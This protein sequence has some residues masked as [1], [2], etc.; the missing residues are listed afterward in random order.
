MNKHTATARILCLLWLLCHGIFPSVAQGDTLHAVPSLTADR[1]LTVRE[2]YLPYDERH[3]VGQDSTDVHHAFVT[4]RI[5]DDYPYAEP[6]E[7]PFNVRINGAYMALYND[8]NYWGGTVDFGSFE[9]QDGADIHID[10]ICKDSLR[11]F[12]LLPLSQDYSVSRTAPNALRLTTHAANRQVTLIANGDGHTGQ[13]LHLF[14]NPITTVE[15]PTDADYYFGPGYHNLT[16]RYGG[17]LTITARQHVYVAPGAVVDGTLRI[18][19]A[20]GAR[21]SGGGMVVNTGGSLL[22]IDNSRHCTVSGITLHGHRPQGWQATVYGSEYI[23]VSHLKILCTRYASTDGLNFVSSSHCQTDSCFIRAC[24]DAIAIKG[25]G[26][27]R[28]DRSPEVTDLRFNHLQLWNDCNNAFSIGAET[29]ARRFSHISLTDTDILFSYDDPQYHTQLDERAALGLCC[30]HGTFFHDIHYDDIRVYHCERL[31][32]MGFKPSFWFGTIPGDQSTQGGIR[33]VTFRNVRSLTRSDSPIANEIL[34]NAWQQEG[35]PTKLIEDIRFDHVMAEGQPIDRVGH[36]LLKINH[37]RLV[38]A[39]CF[40][41]SATASRQ[42][43][44]S[45]VSLQPLFSDGMVLQQQSQ[46]PVW[47]TATPGATITVTPSWNR[48]ACTATADSQGHWELRLSTPEAGGP[49]EMDILSDRDT[50][51]TLHDILIGE[52]WLCSGQS[53]M[54]MPLTGWG[55]IMNYEREIAAADHPQLRLLHVDYTMSPQPENQLRTLGGGW[56]HCTSQSVAGFSA[57]AYFFGRD[58]LQSRQVPVGLIQAAWGGTPAEAWV[59]SEGLSRLPDYKEAVARIRRLPVDASERKAFYEDELTQW[60]R[61]L[62]AD[63]DAWHA[64]ILHYGQPDYDDRLWDD[65]PVPGYASGQGY[66]DFDGI[67]WYRTTI[68]IPSQWA[69]EEL[70]LDLGRIDDN[71]LTFFN[72]RPIGHTDGYAEH[73]RYHVPSEWVRPGKAVITVRVLDIGGGAGLMD[74]VRLQGRPLTSR[75]KMRRA[76]PLHTLAAQPRNPLT[77][78][79]NACMLYNAMIHPLAPY[80]IKGVLWYQGEDN[81]NRAYQ[82]RELLPC[83]IDDWRN[84]WGYGFPF[85]IAQLANYQPRKPQ[86]TASKW[87]ELREAQQLTARHTPQCA[88]ACLIDTGTADDIHPK[89]KQAAGHRL[90]LLARALTYGEDVEYSGPTYTGHE[91]EGGSV[92]LH[93]SHA[94]GLHFTAADVHSAF[95]VAGPDHRFHWA[96]ARIEGTDIVVSSPDVPLPVAV[97]YGWA[98]NPTA[99]LTNGSGLPAHPFRTDDWPGLTF[100]N[101][102][103]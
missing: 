46:V 6:V 64:G 41:P 10:I 20:D 78:A 21:I 4:H 12:E 100:G 62:Q 5:P 85:Y 17:P 18:S 13:V 67:L 22:N 73:R 99:C 30:L 75:W 65:A 25:M 58:I 80:T 15:R 36:P 11:T 61:L 1:P 60:N 70:T 88:T 23:H 98:D 27:Q 68:D 24:D 45:R 37:P 94:D 55:R 28:P 40:T 43:A 91:V 42:S 2:H 33:H 44:S 32:A 26:N 74:T 47:G 89:N 51:I 92:R 86:P 54:D 29:R 76:Q 16:Q 14:C 63:G 52:V 77:D 102:D 83:L 66:D 96:E 8:R 53:N 95:S 56:Q 50:G 9:M 84:R 79:K 103:Y 34:L 101:T 81:A 49:Y 31:I 87:A 19:A 3:C 90:A 69:G 48:Q 39:L 7:R 82:Y 93:F 38:R 71:D 35:T 57:A 72:D 59:S 97:R